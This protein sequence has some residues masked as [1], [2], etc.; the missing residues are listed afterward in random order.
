M[1]EHK[2]TP[3]P[4]RVDE[5]VAFGAYG[6]WTDYATHP[7]HDGAGYGS[8]ICSMKPHDDTGVVREQRDANA[9]LIAASPEL[10]SLLESLRK[11]V[12]SALCPDKW[13]TGETQPH[14]DE[15]MSITVAISKA[16]SGER[17]R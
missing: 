2:H 13:T 15:C 12:C 1:G 10:L 14:C 5:T 3:G 11:P 17:L 16:T 4:W 7:G 6:V 8:Q 9:R